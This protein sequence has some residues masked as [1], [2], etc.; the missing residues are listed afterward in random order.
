MKSQNLATPPFD[1]YPD[2]RGCKFK[3][4]CPTGSQVPSWISSLTSLSQLLQACEQ[5][6]PYVLSGC[7]D[8]GLSVPGALGVLAGTNFAGMWF[9]LLCPE[10]MGKTLEELNGTA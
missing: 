5:C 10:P 1:I 2:T 3:N 8:Y 4:N 9:T 7:A 6:I